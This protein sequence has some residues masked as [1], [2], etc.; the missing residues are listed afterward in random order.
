[1]PTWGKSFSAL[2]Q[3]A[4]HLQVNFFF[5]FEQQSIAIYRVDISISV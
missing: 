3:A 2:A 5:F 1:M 4:A